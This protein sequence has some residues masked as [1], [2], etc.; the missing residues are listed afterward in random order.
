MT[1]TSTTFHLIL[2]ALVLIAAAGDIARFEIPNWLCLSIVFLFPIAALLTPGPAP[3]LS[4]L[5]ASIL[6]LSVGLLIFNFK[7]MG[8]GDV[9]LLAAIAVWTGLS[10]LVTLMLATAIAGGFVSASLLTARYAVQKLQSNAGDDT[11]HKE[12]IRVLQKDA[13]MPYGVAIAL[14][15]LFLIAQT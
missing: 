9:K 11:P 2:A 12:P 5:A 14:G 13:P 7:V 1:D 3:W 4:H 8:G 6:I 10:D 15:T